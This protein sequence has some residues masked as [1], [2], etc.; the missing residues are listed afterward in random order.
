[1]VVNRRRLIALGLV[2]VAIGAYLFLAP[3][4]SETE[5]VIDLGAR[6]TKVRELELHFL[7]DGSVVRDLT[8]PF[9]D[10]APSQVRHGLRLRNGAYQVA[11]RMRWS[12]GRESH[13]G[14]DFA[15]DAPQPLDLTA[16]R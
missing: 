3:R 12:D 2:P 14:R 9:P 11:V 7:R 4:Y 1:M 16:L 5:V 13:V 10:G 6:A 15:T 8:L